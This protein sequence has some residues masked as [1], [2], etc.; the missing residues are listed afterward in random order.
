MDFGLI[1]VLYIMD[2]EITLKIEFSY[3]VLVLYILAGPLNLF[4]YLFLDMPEST[5]RNHLDYIIQFRKLSS[6]GFI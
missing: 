1:M 2:R 3:G 4:W 6:G 5:G